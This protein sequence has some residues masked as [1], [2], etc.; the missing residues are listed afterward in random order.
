MC[1]DSEFSSSRFCSIQQD[2]II[3]YVTSITKCGSTSCSSD[4]SL[5]PANCGCAYPYMGTIFFRSPLFADLTNNDHFQQLETSL[6][7]ELGL[8]AGSVFLSDVRFTSD[9]YLQVK[10]RMF[11]ST[12]TSFN[13]SEVTRIGSELSSQAYKPPPGFGP[14]FFVA[15]P[16][17]HFAGIRIIKYNHVKLC[18]NVIK[19]V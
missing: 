12:G 8:Q 4:Q 16:Y 5:N 18:L 15:D 1:L 11:P 3:P 17:A 7:T 2:S 14:Y 13:V 10:V 9:D 6:W 19:Y